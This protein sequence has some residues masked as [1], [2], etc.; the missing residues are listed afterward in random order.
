M[1]NRVKGNKQKSAKGSE[2]HESTELLES[3]DALRDTLVDKTGSF[4]KSKKNQNIAFGIGAA[5]ALVIAGIFG[6]TYYMDSQNEAAQDEMF[7][8]VFYFEADSLDR[9]LN[10]DG[11]NF[12]FL[13]IIDEYGGTGAANLA[14]YYAG[15]AL[16]KQGNY[17]QAIDHLTSFSASDLLVQ[18][19]AYALVGDAYMELQNYS[20]AANYYN[21]A[22]SY[23]PN[24]FFTPQYLVKAALAYEEMGEFEEAAES[25]GRIVEE[26]PEATE[27]QQA[28]KQQVRL[29]SL[30]AGE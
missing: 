25:Y 15:I 19:R 30:A 16:L 7:Q 6:Y 22:I 21:K 4:F 10:G 17:N 29:Q 13:E 14:H 1:A 24:R 12:G 23:K 28:L 26:F 3:P 8:A 27:Y 9:A 5:I 2:Q 11:N 18:A 20:E